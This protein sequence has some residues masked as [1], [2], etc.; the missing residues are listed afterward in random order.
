MLCCCGKVSSCWT[1]SHHPSIHSPSFHPFLTEIQYLLWG[2][3]STDK[4]EFALFHHVP[5]SC[6]THSEQPGCD[7]C[8][9]VS[10]IFLC[11]TQNNHSL[12]GY[13]CFFFETPQQQSI[14]IDYFYNNSIRHHSHH[15]RDRRSRS[16]PQ[17]ASATIAQSHS[18]F[19]HGH[20][21]FARSHSP[22]IA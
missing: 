12:S 19:Q 17:I 22:Q 9:L 21:R 2:S 3:H 10:Q 11:P 1:S 16:G 15:G 4:T 7:Q 8:Y 18:L 13:C 6:G 5:N 14:K 20:C